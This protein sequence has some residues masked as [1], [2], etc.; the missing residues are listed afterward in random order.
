[1]ALARSRS[2]AF[3][4]F[5]LGVSRQLRTL[6]SSAVK[7]EKVSCSVT[8]SWS[9]SLLSIV[10]VISVTLVMALDRTLLFLPKA[11]EV[12]ATWFRAFSLVEADSH[13]EEPLMFTE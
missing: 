1:M 8:F 3:E 11:E 4:L 6:T 9:L 2:P 13:L 7:F 5:K 12:L 10:W